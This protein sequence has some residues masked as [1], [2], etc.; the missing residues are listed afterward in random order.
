MLFCVP[1]TLSGMNHVAGPLQK[2]YRQHKKEAPA[3][4]HRPEQKQQ[5]ARAKRCT[6]SITMTSPRVAVNSSIYVGLRLVEFAK[7]KLRPSL[8]NIWSFVDV[9]YWQ[10]KEASDT[11][12]QPTCVS[13]AQH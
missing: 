9:L 3:T 11:L 10:L 4:L 13:S 2:W 1:W 7:L 5:L 12:P 6:S 8:W